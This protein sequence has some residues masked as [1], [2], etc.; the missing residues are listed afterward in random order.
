MALCAPGHAAFDGKTNLVCSVTDVIGCSDARAC[1]QGPARS[2]DLP[3]F[4]AVDFTKKQVHATKESGENV[5]SPFKDPMETRN[6]LV[7]QG[8]ENGHGWTVAIDRRHGRM[9]TNT[10]GED[11]SY[12]LFGAC[13]AR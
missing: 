2:F 13:I 6:Q 4:I 12:I 5:V 3:Q 9:T 7:M 8:V 1:V 11:V 10:T